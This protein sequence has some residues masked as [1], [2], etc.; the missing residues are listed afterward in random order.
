M[1]VQLGRLTTAFFSSGIKCLDPLALISMKI[2]T[3]V[4]KG[5]FPAELV[6]LYRHLLLFNLKGGEDLKRLLY[7]F[8]KKEKC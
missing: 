4:M 1:R 6:L 7:L 5:W 3:D 8:F 2:L